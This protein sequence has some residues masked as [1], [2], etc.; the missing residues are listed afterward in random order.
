[1][2]AEKAD[3]TSC[4]NSDCI[5]KKNYHG[6]GGKELIAKKHTVLCKKNQNFII[7][8]SPVHGLYFIYKGKA[9]VAKTGIHGREQI[10]R[11]AKDGETIGHRGFGSGQFYQ[12]SAVAMEDTILCHFGNEVLKDMLTVREKVIDA[13]LYMH[14]K[15]GLLNGFL[16]VQLSRKEIADFAGTTDEQVIR[17]LSSLKKEALIHTKGKKIGLTDREILR[18]EI[19]VHNYFLDS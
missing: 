9:K 19:A 7:E 1:M 15:F 13:L 4:I 6:E 3:C 5:I 11:F 14:R 12:I 16:N 17:V 2:R 10:V 18:K 8:G